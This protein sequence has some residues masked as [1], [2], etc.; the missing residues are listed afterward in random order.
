MQRNDLIYDMYRRRIQSGLDYDGGKFCSGDGFID[1]RGIQYSS[2]Y[3][4]RMI[5]NPVN[6]S[7]RHMMSGS[8]LRSKKAKSNLAM[9]RKWYDNMKMK[10]PNATKQMLNMTWKKLHKK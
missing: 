5:E 4:S 6:I 7:R 9:Y 10:H 8:A 1:P 3:P 2:V